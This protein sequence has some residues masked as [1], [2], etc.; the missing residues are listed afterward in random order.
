MMS[1]ESQAE[2]EANSPSKRVINLP[3]VDLTADAFQPFGQVNNS[4]HLLSP[5]MVS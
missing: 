4:L 3:V 1:N 5:C 2:S